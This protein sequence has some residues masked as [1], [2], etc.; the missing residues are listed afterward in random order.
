MR[1]L[2][3]FFAVLV[4]PLGARAQNVQ[5]NNQGIIVNQVIVP[6]YSTRPSEIEILD[7]YLD[8]RPPLYS[9]SAPPAPVSYS[10]NYFPDNSTSFGRTVL[11]TTAAVNLRKTP[12]SKGILVCRL[13]EHTRVADASQEDYRHSW[14]AYKIA[15]P[16]SQFAEPL[17]GWV[18]VTVL[19]SRSRVSQTGFVRGEFLTER[20]NYLP[21]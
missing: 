12:S 3:S 7:K 15:P 11:H 19:D 13:P 2:F 10:N 20:G 18:E 17:S 6:V 4:L 16:P 8:S 21:D 1:K 14:F 9:T 5:T